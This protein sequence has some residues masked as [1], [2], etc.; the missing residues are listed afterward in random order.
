MDAPRPIVW[1]NLVGM[2]PRLLTHAPRL[3]RLAEAGFAAPLGGVLP[4]VTCSAQATAL[5]GLAPGGHGVVANGWMHRD[6]GEIRFWL[7]SNRLVQGETIYAAAKKRAAEAGRPFKCAKMFWWFNQGAP[8]D[9]SVTPKPWY[10]ADGSKAF[11]IHGEPPELV[12]KLEKRHGKFPFFSF[13]GPKAGRPSTDW[14]ARASATVIQEERPD[15][16][17]V[18][19]P[20]LDYDFQRYGPLFEGT[21]D[22][23]RELDHAAAIVIDAAHEVGADVLAFSEYGILPVSTHETP[24]RVLRETGFLE[25]RDG[26]YGETIGHLP[27]AR[28]GGV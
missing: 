3:K 24:N 23:V 28:R 17:L 12:A 19:L 22:R 26:P 13:W 15:L 9:I 6:T 4:A 1:L 25:V 16:T 20:H 18:Y 2:T 11:G 10:G 14:I 8:V 5:T 7:Q 21:V 27:L